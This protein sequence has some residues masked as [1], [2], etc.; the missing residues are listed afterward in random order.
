MPEKNGYDAV[1]VGSGPN[2]LAA[3]ITLLRAKKR[4]LV[5]EAKET[6]GGGMRTGELTLPGFQH[7]ICSAIHPLGIASPFFRSL[8]LAQHG[9]KWIYAPAALSHPLDNGQ[10]ALLTNSVVETAKTLREDSERY[11][12]LIEPLLSRWELILPEIL[13]P[14]HIPRHPLALLRFGLSAIQSAA[15]FSKRKFNSPLTRGFFAGLAAHSIVPLEEPITAAFALVLGILGHSA[16]WPMP[17]GGSQSIA[18]AL[19]SYIKSLGGEFLLSTK[20]NSLDELPHSDIVLFDLTPKQILAIAG[21]RLPKG[22]RRQLER[23]RYGPGVFKMDFAVKSPIP[24][25]SP[26]CTLS[27]VVHLGGTMEEIAHSEQE[28]WQ[29]RHPERPFVILAQ[30]SLFDSTRAP[31]GNHTVWAYCHVPNDSDTD[32]S[33]RIISQIERFAPG[34][35]GTILS[36]HKMNSH[37]FEAYNNNYVGG[38]I[39]GGV[40]NWRQLFT[41][42]TLSLT[43]YRTPIKGVY[44][45]S[46]STPPGGG[47]HGMCG[48]YAARTALKDV[49]KI[50]AMI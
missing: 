6:I 19:Q 35:R 37:N 24:F 12:R 10:A 39:N 47:V 50:K 25:K 4:V 46:S 26:E 27:A 30:Q 40:Q 43:P 21:E 9:L 28:V 29:G 32:M 45:C 36:S 16:G 18:L 3:A 34:F 23:Y 48:Y 8:P 5:I 49:Y 44:I 38:D 22:Y 17:E 11:R 13:A 1:I 31:K 15:K 7:D 42:P 33:E 2:G 41:R 14:F 20:I